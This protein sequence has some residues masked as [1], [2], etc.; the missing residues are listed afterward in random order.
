MTEIVVKIRYPFLSLQNQ[1]I[2]LSNRHQ[3]RW[4][5]AWCRHR[6][7]SGH[8]LPTPQLGLHL[9]SPSLLRNS[10]ISPNPQSKPLKAINSTIPVISGHRRLLLSSVQAS[11]S[12]SAAAQGS[13][14]EQWDSLTAKLAGSANLPFLLLQ[15]PQIVL[16]ARNLLSGNPSALRA[17]PWLGMLTGLL[18]NLSL[19]SYFAKKRETEAVLVQTSGVISTYV[20]ILQL[21]MAQAMPLPQ[22]VATSVVVSLGFVLNFLNYFSRLDESL[23]RLW[24][25]F[26]TIGGLSVLPQVM[27]S[28][29]VPFVPNSILPGVVSCVLGVG[30]VVMKCRHE[31]GK[32]SEEG[33]KLVGALAGWTATLLFMWMP[34][35]QMWTSY[36]N[37]DNIRG[38]SSFTMLLAM[39]GNGLMIP[40]ALFI[41]DLMW[42]TGSAWGTMFYGWGNLACMY[43]FST[44]SR[45]F[46]LA[47]TV[48]LLLWLGTSLWR[49]T[50][51]HGY[52]SPMK[53]IK[54][55][56]FGP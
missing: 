42:F 35:A 24:E 48:G 51:A 13:A 3:W 43:C 39:I 5:Q 29:F 7:V 28:T 22:F 9:S 33:I 46:F 34:V 25:D 44:I 30:A 31:L 2:H 21:A 6:S 4:L 45:E 41:R 37:P 17:V 23:W 11:P 47:A 36:L 38:L 54:E 56:L 50:A 55:L 40:R 12:N 53:S 26:I 49:D 18:G 20:V 52:N 19:L 10:L 15:L 1:A 8:F 27:W 14:F 16:N 32:L